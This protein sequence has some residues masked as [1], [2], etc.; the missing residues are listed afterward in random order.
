MEQCNCPEVVTVSFHFRLLCN[1]R[2]KEKLN[3]DGRR[4]AKAG[5]QV[6]DD[7]LDWI[8]AQ[9]EG[10]VSNESPHCSCLS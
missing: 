1:H 2:L 10:W 5:K 3:Q 7:C 4:P 9:G 6:C 8:R